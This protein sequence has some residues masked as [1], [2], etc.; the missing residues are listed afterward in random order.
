MKISPKI[1]IIIPIFNVAK[2]IRCALDS[3]INQTLS[4][5]EIIC[6]NDCTPDESFEIVREYAANDSRFVL[7][8]FESNQGQ[9]AARNYALSVAQGDYIMFLDPD[10]WLTAD[11]CEKAYNQIF[12]N[13]N[14][15][16]FF[17]CY[18]NR[19][20]YNGK[21]REKI[22]RARDEIFKKL[23]NIDHVCLASGAVSFFSAMSVIQI[24][25]KEF[26]SRHRI[27]FSE[28]RFAE[29]LQ[30]MVKL[31]VANADVSFLNE[32][33]YHYL[34]KKSY[35]IVDYSKMFDK[36]L[37]TKK[38]AMQIISDSPFAAHL[39][40][41]FLK[42]EICSDLYFFKIFSYRNPHDSKKNY[43]KLRQRFL[44]L[45]PVAAKLDYDE[46]FLTDF[47]LILKCDTLYKFKIYRLWAKICRKYSVISK[48]IKQQ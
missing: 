31:Y 2:Y 26:L 7:L 27:D 45:D 11:A 13:C 42:Y 3:V 8:E 30:F 16:V 46:K 39:T 1:S 44:E 24:Y 41:L 29:D 47:K 35:S 5:I 15:A 18:E 9:G 6:V 33:L 22:S 34:M 48:K 32:P 19:E 10:D 36:V 17:N 40:T 28:H 12:S 14:D 4:D 37:V 23:E 21:N 43:I 20:F 25:S 38:E